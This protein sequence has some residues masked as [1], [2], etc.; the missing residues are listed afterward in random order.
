MTT[1]PAPSITTHTLTGSQTGPFPTGWTYAEA[2]DVR[3]WIEVE[4]QPGAVL[5]QGTAYTLTGSSPLTAG[6]T[7]NLSVA[8]VPAGGWAAE[9][10]LVLRR[11]TARRQG[12]ALPDTEGH[13]PRVT[14]RA[15]DKQMRIAEE[16]RDDLDRAILAPP[17]EGGLVLP[18]LPQRANRIL[19]F[20]E[21]GLRLRADVAPED[22]DVFHKADRTLANVLGSVLGA[23]QIRVDG[24]SVDLPIA[25]TLGLTLHPEH[26]GGVADD[27]SAPAA[28]ANKAAFE[29]AAAEGE[30]LDGFDRVYAIEGRWTPSAGP[31]LKN[32]RF[33]RVVN[34]G[35][36]NAKLIDISN[37][38]GVHLENVR[39]D[40]GG[41]AAPAGVAM[42]EAQGVKVFNCD[43]VV[44]FD[45]KVRNGQGHT[46]LLVELCT[47]VRLR[48]VEA[49]DFNVVL[50]A[51]PSDDVCQGVSLLQCSEMF[52]TNVGGVNLGA[53][54]PG[55]PAP[56]RLYSRGV[57]MSGC[58]NFHMHGLYAGFVDQGVDITGQ[59]N[60]DGLITGTRTWDCSTYGL[61]LANRNHHLHV[62]GG[63]IQRAG[64][65]GVVI[66]SAY[67]AG[68]PPMTERMVI[69]N[70]EIVDTGANSIYTQSDGRN[71]VQILSSGLYPG[72]PGGID[73]VNTRVYDRQAVKTTDAWFA[74][75]GASTVQPADSTV[76]V[77]RLINCD[78]EGLAVGGVP[79]L[80]F[81]FPDVKATGAGNQSLPTSGS[82]VALTFATALRNSSNLISGSRFYAKESGLYLV[83]VLIEFDANGT[84][85]RE[86]LFYKNGVE[87]HSRD[88]ARVAADA[89]GNNPRLQATRII[90]LN[91]GDYVEVYGY[92]NSGGALNAVLAASFFE[93]IKLTSLH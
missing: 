60:S 58:S 19:A 41:F 18:G 68:I 8:L 33:K 46:G 88:R 6:G 48:N 54:W 27:T 73:I 11:R 22:F 70:F 34:S 78:G 52:A 40:L 53:S 82:A 61:K 21:T 29:Q 42:S 23:K 69:D 51:Q 10:R 75:R 50:A 44:I 30:I 12:T 24:A 17:G 39:I 7:V 65:A 83:N 80:G 14:E 3:A 49:A 31:R 59:P 43:D 71:G 74:Q 2:T 89:S 28:A 1:T 16:D 15:L 25:R 85:R 92:H 76:P 77:N 32:V 86:L 57:A 47:R 72:Y 67:V 35:A 45:V 13:K 66:S 55:M 84:G 93:M 64:W 56:R 63:L 38:T 36:A 79:Q 81:N 26:F 62:S 9:T 91:R 90:P 20:D 5:N 37:K 4:G 87:T